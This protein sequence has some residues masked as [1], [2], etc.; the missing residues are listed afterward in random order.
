MEYEDFKLE[1]MKTLSIDPAFDAEFYKNASRD[2]IAD[3]LNEQIRQEY[4]QRSDA[5]VAQAWP[6][7]KTIC[8]KQ[9]ERFVNVAVPVGDGTKVMRV[10][11]NLKKAYETQGREL[12]RA[13]SKTI[14]LIMIDEAWKEHLR[15]M[16]DLKQS[17][18]NA[19]YE[20][21]DPLLVYKFES[22]NLFK[23]VIERISR[24][25]VKFLLR[26]HIPVRENAPGD[27]REAEHRRT[28][29]SNMRTSR[30]D[31]VTNSGEPKS[32]APVRVEKKVGRNDPCPCGSGKKY[33]HCHGRFENN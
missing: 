2:K 25:V 24:E 15:D 23:S 19:T 26:A 13:V 8:E 21:K 11:V 27:V 7:I 22:F 29:M 20:Q 28:D 9:G 10:L 18:Q 31:M 6:V 14:T 16:D 1:V 30:T 12:I 17:V 33:K 3:A 4:Q 5:M 32:N